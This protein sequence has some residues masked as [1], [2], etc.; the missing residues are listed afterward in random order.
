MSTIAQDVRLARRMLFKSPL[1]TAIVISTLSLAIGL[2][3]AVFSAVDAL[4]LR[5]LPGV[6]E[7]GQLVQLFRSWPGDMKYGS[8]SL[9]HYTDL[10]DKTGDVF[11]G[12]AL[13]SFN[14]LNVAT[15]GEPK[16]V[17]SMLASANY[18]TVL[19]VKAVR[20]RLFVPQEDSGRMAHPVAVISSA[21]WKGMFGSDSSVVGRKV[22]IN[23]GTYEIIGVAAPEFSGVIP[24][25]TPAFWVPLS[26]HDQIRPGNSG[27]WDQR[28]NNSYS[29]VARIKPGVSLPAVRNRMDALVSELRQAHPDDYKESGITVVPQGEAG[30]HPMFKTAEV[31][32]SAVVMAVVALLLLIACVNVAN[33]FLARARDRAREMA[34]RL[35]LGAT[36]AALIRQLLIESLVF[37]GI[38][39]IIGL[40]IAEWA[41]TLGNQITLPLDVD[42]T[43]GLELSPTVLAFTVIASVVAALLFGIAPAIQATRPSLVPALKGEAPAGQSRSRMRNGLVVAQMALSIVL[44]V[45]AGLFLRNLKAATN[46]D[47]GFVS[48]NLLVAALD[49]GMQGYP[50]ARSEEFFRLL[51]QR[52]SAHPAVTAV[53][54]AG[55]IPLGLS[56]SDSHTTIPGYVPAPNENMGVQLNT[57]TPGYFEAMGIPLTSGRGFL[58]RDD[59]ASQRVLVVN[60]QFVTKYFGG[61]DPLGKTVHVHGKDHTVIGVVPTGKYMRLGESPTPFM[62]FAQAQDWD[63]GVFIHIRTTGDPAALIP[64]LRTEVA[65][66]DPSLPLSDAKPMSRMLGIALLPARLIGAVL[67]IFGVLGLLMAA[68]GMYGVM[69]Y[70]VSQRTREI[71]IRMAIGAAT[72]DV[73]RLVM[74]QGLTL[75]VIGA[76]IGLAGAFAVSRLIA[77]VLYGSGANDPVT[78]VAVPLLLIGVAVLATWIPARRAAATDPLAA[79]R[80]E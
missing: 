45:C 27:N 8:N 34:V 47:K 52:I 38:S 55:S 49:P 42:F 17:M 59:S 58:A 25:V 23:G 18:F 1:F 15:G 30:I 29:V 61:R 21:T 71:G 4:L 16:R 37:A 77:G 44:L 41:I 39:A 70:S 19:G 2:N 24:I 68:I 69:A 13:W 62:Y 31:G 6:Q 26:Q 5:P 75:V 54:F 35:S 14:S 10:R 33:L 11:S 7:P 73:V 12:V 67:G 50:R 46:A 63:A 36:R 76:G 78:F 64:V 80:Q 48:D 60:Q 32:M 74:R 66:I 65:A 79:L 20:G 56:E 3:T 53:A 51:T 28:G 72:G 22:I 43:A 57:V 9:P 40:G